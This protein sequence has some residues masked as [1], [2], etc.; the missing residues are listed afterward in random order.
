MEK[1]VPKQTKRRMG[2]VYLNSFLTLALDGREWSASRRRHFST[3]RDIPITI[4]E[5]TV[6]VWKGENTLRRESS[7][8]YSKIQTVAYA[9]HRL[10]YPV[11]PNTNTY[12]IK[13]INLIFE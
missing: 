8:P 6:S 12:L 13:C 4:E 9:L 11:I 1:I 5:E 10:S 7:R 3:G 2:G